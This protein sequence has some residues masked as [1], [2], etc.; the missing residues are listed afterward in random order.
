MGKLGISKNRTGESRAFRK[1]NTRSILKQKKNHIELP[2]F[3][4]PQMRES[5]IMLRNEIFN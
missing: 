2:V 3:P 1:K 4:L 5:H